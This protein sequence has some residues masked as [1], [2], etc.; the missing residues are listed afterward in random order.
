MSW[1]CGCGIVNRDS[2]VKCSGCRIPKG[3]VWTPHGIK[4]ADDPVGPRE[5]PR[6][7]QEYGFGWFCVVGGVICFLIGVSTQNLPMV[8]VM[9][10]L[11]SAAA[12]G[13]PWGWYVLVGSHLILI[14][15]IFAVGVVVTAGG[16]W[17]WVKI[18]A[19]SLAVILPSFIYFYK[20]R[21]M[22]GAK[23][24]WR[25]LERIGVGMLEVYEETP[26]ER[27]VSRPGLL[28]ALGAWG[29]IVVLG[30][31]ISL[32]SRKDLITGAKATKLIAS[33]ENYKKQHGTYP[34]NLDGFVKIE[35]CSDGKRAM[36]FR[37][38]NEKTEFSL[39]CFGRGQAIF[40]GEEVWEV[41]SSKTKEWGTISD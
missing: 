13:R 6:R 27:D 40:A 38:Y 37:T 10:L 18:S 9:G 22:L 14:L 35:F 19:G 5:T 26:T 7:K 2:R 34:N 21:V 24:R 4:A 3:M 30:L 29:V 33:L 32:P 11:T 28:G 36:G 39:S 31:G 12:L 16:E 17:P 23:G 1:E 15:Y 41:Y 25:W 8:L 20:R